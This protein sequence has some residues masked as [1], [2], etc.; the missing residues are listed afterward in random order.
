MKQFNAY[1]PL[2]ILAETL[3]QTH[4]NTLF[5]SNSQR[6]ADFHV[7]MPGA[8]L[9]FSKQK[10]T[11][12]VLDGLIGMAEEAN[13]ADWIN[14]LI[15]GDELNHTEG[16]KA[17]HTALRNMS[18]PIPEV[19]EA[20]QKM[21][22]IVDELHQ[23]QM[24]GYSGKAITDV[25]NIGV[26]GSDLGPLMITHALEMQQL[27]S[28]PQIHF[29]S[30]LDGRQLQSILA[31]TNP[32]TTLFIVASKS[33]TTIDT[34]SLAETA[35]SWILNS[36][37]NHSEAMRHFIG[38]STSPE[39][40]GEWGILPQ[41]QL[42]FWDWVGGR[43]S[44]WSTI[45]LTVAIQLGMDGFK[46]MLKGAHEVDEHFRKTPFRENIPVLI[47]LIGIW[48][49]NF[50]K[51][52]GQAI[53]PYDSRLKHFASYLEQLE[54]ESNGKHTQRNGEFVDYRT[55]P[56]LW[57]EVGPN[58]QHAFYQLL[59]QGTERVM[60]DFILFK[61]GQGSGERAAFHQN[62][63]IANCLAQSRAMMVGQD[64]DNPH[65]HYPGDQV[66]NTLLMTR[67]D[68]HHLGMLVAIYEH[69]V[70]TQSVIWNINPFDQWGVELG[71]KLA[72]GIL[73]SIDRQDAS[74]LDQSTQGILQQIWEH[75]A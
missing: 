52:A 11:Q 6:F 60:S 42:A 41:M 27:P 24:R 37:Q 18:D 8:M 30:T 3:Q 16:R 53:L 57:G 45:G 12:E 2:S 25:V 49:T 54:M 34:L 36:C 64:S 72:M 51:L 31:K 33:F 74:E 5:A 59:H 63:N 47:G 28:S 14:R 7:Q 20:W 68:A 73:D 55:C 13:L 46:Q 29:V 9:D 48:N 43:F 26:G 75:K 1:Q 23:K 69:K 19:A 38:I 71:K 10:I 62:L 67:V 32:E 17:W 15:N 56:I 35:K 40:M 22:Y 21:A 61:E 58:A 39:K 70:F 4:L 50:L 65:K 44:M 66:S